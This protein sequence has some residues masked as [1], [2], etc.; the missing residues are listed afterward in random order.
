MS[1]LPKENW[2]SIHIFAILLG[3]F[4]LS[5][6][7]SPLGKLVINTHIYHISIS[8][9]SCLLKEN[10]LS[11]HIFTILVDLFFPR[12]VLPPFGNWL[13]IHTFTILAFL[14]YPVFLRKTGYEYTYLL[15][16]FFQVLSPVL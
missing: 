16:N 9:M 12:P 11:I 10:W 3:L 14:P 8:S 6:V 15:L 7:L 4:L 13:C 2:S 5:P 1:C